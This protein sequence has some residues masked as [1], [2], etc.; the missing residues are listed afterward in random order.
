VGRGAKDKIRKI[1]ERF[2]HDSFDFL[3]LVYDG[4]PYDD[5]CFAGCTVVQDKSPL[6]WQLKAQ[7]TPEL[8]RRYEYV[9]VW[10]DDLDVLDFDPQNF[11]QIMRTHKIQVAQP[12]LSQDSI[13]SYQIVAHQ[14]GCVGRY[15]DFVEE[16]ALVFR[17]DLWERFW[18][19]IVPD[20]NPWGWGYDE[21]TY[22]FC[23]FRR[24]AIIDAEVIRHTHAGSYHDI[25]IA[26]HHRAREHFRRFHLSRKRTLGVI[27]NAP[28]RKHVI[29]PVRLM[30]YHILIVLYSLR[31]VFFLRR[32]I[33]TSAGYLRAMASARK[34]S[35]FSV[36]DKDSGDRSHKSQRA[37]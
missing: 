26:D 4:T 16:M 29:V 22:S 35:G 23:G 15:T 37:C 32:A 7:L 10:M 25:A 24:M 18:S 3:L 6:F 21:F 30:L 14:D 36:T 33:R 27:S 19:L 1:V 13:R 5:A 11:L 28:W 8:C 31:P 9:F 20:A 2:G 17:G 12:S 34:E